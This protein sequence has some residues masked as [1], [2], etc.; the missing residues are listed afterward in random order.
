MSKENI[1]PQINPETEKMRERVDELRKTDNKYT[2]SVRVLAENEKEFRKELEKELSKK[3]AVNQLANMYS[4]KDLEKI[5]AEKQKWVDDLTGLKNKNAFSQEIPIL[6][7][8]EKRD[9]TDCSL[10]VIDFD[11][12]KK[13][14]DEYG[15]L[16]GDRVLKKMTETLKKLIRSFDII[17][18]YGGEE[19]VI[20][21][22]STIASQAV[23]IAE[24]IR[25]EIE[26]S[27]FKITDNNGIEITLKKTISI[28]CAGTDQFKEWDEFKSDKINGSSKFLK[29]IFRAADSATIISKKTGRNKVT[30]F[31]E[32]KKNF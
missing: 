11:F 30:L 19:F 27:E 4:T 32:K 21:L 16:A 29:K 6:L 28:G 22:P 1:E 10:L 5:E 18:R 23:G 7:N 9:N 25:S 31:D 3:E 15:H 8:I 26:N 2:D 14:N 12:F 24:K 20:F 13:I 17:Y